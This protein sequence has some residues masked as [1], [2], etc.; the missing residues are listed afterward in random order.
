LCIGEFL[1]IRRHLAAA[2]KMMMIMAMKNEEV[3]RETTRQEHTQAP[4]TAAAD[5]MKFRTVSPADGLVGQ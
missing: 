1:R 2:V 5:L 4:T 3:H